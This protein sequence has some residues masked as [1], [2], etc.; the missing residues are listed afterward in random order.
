M[1]NS[2]VRKNQDLSE[3]IEHNL[4]FGFY[5]VF[6]IVNVVFA[7]TEGDI[8]SLSMLASISIGLSLWY[9]PSF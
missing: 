4:F 8:A 1:R 7:V 3:R 2:Q 5:V 6:M 9:L